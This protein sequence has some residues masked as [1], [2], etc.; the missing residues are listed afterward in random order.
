MQLTTVR[1]PTQDEF[2][3]IVLAMGMRIIAVREES[4]ENKYTLEAGRLTIEVPSACWWK[5]IEEA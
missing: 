2:E 5:V 3:A 1:Q 4:G